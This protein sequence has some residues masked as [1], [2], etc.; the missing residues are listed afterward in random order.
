[1]INPSLLQHMLLFAGRYEKS[2]SFFERIIYIQGP[3][4]KFL[5]LDNIHMFEH[6]GTYLVLPLNILKPLQEKLT[7]V[8]I[9]SNTPCILCPLSS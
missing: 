5:P 4:R 9:Q 3:Y 7:K 2:F 6:S 1:M 8:N